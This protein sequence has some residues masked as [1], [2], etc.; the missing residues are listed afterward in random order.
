MPVTECGRTRL[1]LTEERRRLI[2]PLVDQ[3]DA[4]L[5]TLRDLQLGETEP[6]TAG[7]GE[8]PCTP[9]S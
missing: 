2:A 9:M 7:S 5:A 1:P 3:L 4:V 6:D 8:T